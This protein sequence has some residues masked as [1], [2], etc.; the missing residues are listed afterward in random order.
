MLERQIQAP[1]GLAI[2]GV[3]QTDAPINPGNSGGPLV[4]EGGEVIG[5]V[6]WIFADINS[7]IETGGEHG[8]SV[9]TLSPSRSISS[10]ATS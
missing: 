9:G 2:D 8:C 1:N 4:N 6:G 7:Q 10:R 3:L 5:V